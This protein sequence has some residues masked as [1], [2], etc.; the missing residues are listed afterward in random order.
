MP[1]NQIRVPIRLGA[2]GLN[3]SRNPSEV[4][5]GGLIDADNISFE[6][7]ALGREGGA[8]KA[9]SRALDSNSYAL[10]GYSFRPSEGVKLNVVLLS[11]GAY[12]LDNDDDGDYVDGRASNTAGQVWQVDA[13]GGPSYV[14]ETTDFNDSGGGDDADLQPFPTS[15]AVGDWFAIG[16]LRPFERV[17]FDNASGGAA[18][19]VGGTVTWEYWD[20]SA[21]SALSGVSD[22]TSGFT[23][24]KADGQELTFTVPSDWAATT[25]NASASLFYIRARLTGVYSTNP[26]YD[27]GAITADLADGLSVTDAQPFF[28]EGG[29]EA[30]AN[31][32]KLFMFTGTD[33][34]Q[35]I[36]GNATTSSALGTPPTDWSGTNQPTGGFILGGRLWGYG[37]SNQPH[38]LYYST[39]TDHEDL[40][41]AG[42]GT[43]SVYPGAGDKI[44]AAVVFKGFPVIFKYPRGIYY[45][46]ARD[47]DIANWLIHQLTDKVGTLNAHTIQIIEDDVAFMDVQGQVHLLSQ[48]GE[49]NF[50]TRNLSVAE[51]MDEY[52]RN[53]VNIGQLSKARSVYYPAKQELHFAVPET[54]QSNNTARIVID[55]GRDNPRFRVSSRDDPF[56][57]WL[58][59]DSNGVER[60]I[61]SDTNGF[62]WD[63]DTVNFN[64]DG[65]TYLSRFQTGYM[66][67]SEIDLSLA[68]RKKNVKAIEVEA[69]PRG[70][71]TFQVTVFFDERVSDGKSI[72]VASAGFT[73][74]TDQLG[75]GTLGASRL[76][77][78]RRRISGSGY[79]ISVAVSV[80]GLNENV[81]ISR[82]TLFMTPGQP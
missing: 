78:E 70:S 50:G 51:G 26:L 13:D 16:Y 21:W 55:F 53:E 19:G 60:I 3:G 58:E 45:V 17:T 15:E 75:T 57:L 12:L 79:R 71:A 67:F 44:V 7:H 37:N 49:E 48:V 76:F 29:K 72:T 8:Q 59:Q 35:V 32:R 24:A 34:V 20:G 31:N 65:S 4:P 25:I 1:A 52:V 81:A 43:V 82:I 30:A 47:P 64:Q 69:F 5:I 38:L 10:G 9:V 63:L 77:R 62:L 46:D 23:A 54:G 18:A 27:N 36:D 11:D 33:A 74:G 42:S 39:L 28:V 80:G 66:D 41:S 68:T 22:G 2:R 73:L 14:D 61:S 40:S 6:G 56:A